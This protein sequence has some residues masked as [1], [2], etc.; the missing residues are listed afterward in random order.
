MSSSTLLKCS[1][2]PK[3][4]SFSDVSHLLT[5]VGSK[6]HLSHL[7]KLQVR[8]HQEIAAGVELA[9]YDQ[10]YQRHGLGRMLSDRMMQKEVKKGNKRG[11]TATRQAKTE[12]EPK[13]RRSHTPVSTPQLHLNRAKKP[14]K[15]TYAP[16]FDG[17]SDYDDSPTRQRG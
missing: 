1:I 13:R 14:R 9:A 15:T 17:D 4:P 10:W 2:C 11:R 16:D 5:H 3:K 12:P 7:H 6:G 8:S